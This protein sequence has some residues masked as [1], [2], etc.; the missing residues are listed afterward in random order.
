MIYN[1]VKG[2]ISNIGKHKGS[3]TLAGL[4]GQR[5]VGVLESPWIT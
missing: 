1:S 4:H 2:G 3:C 5:G